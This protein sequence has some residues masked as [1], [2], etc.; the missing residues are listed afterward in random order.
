[1]VVALLPLLVL[2]LAGSFGADLIGADLAPRHDGALAGIWPLAGPVGIVAV[3]LGTAGLAAR[4]LRRPL[5]EASETIEAIMRAELDAAPEAGTERGTEIDRLMG[6]IDRLAEILREQHRRDLVLIEA[7]RKRRSDRRVNLSNMAREIEETTEGGMRVIVEGSCALRE[8]ADD[9]R[10]T[11]ETVQ[12]ASDE[13][14]RAA[15][16][17]R[18][19]NR[20][21]SGLSDRFIAAIGAIAEQAGSGSAASRDAVHRANNARGVISAVAAQTNLL[22]LNATIEAARAGAAGK[23]FAVVASE[24]KSLANETGKST[25][26]IGAKISEIQSRTH[27]VVASLADVT[28]AIGQVS[29]MTDSISTAMQEQRSAMQGFSDNVRQTNAAVSDVAGRMAEIAS[30]VGRSTA[31]ASIV[32]DVAMD[33]ERASQAVRSEIPDI[34]RRALRAD[35]REHPRYDIDARANL[36]AAG[37]SIDIRVLDISESGARI[38]MVEGVELGTALTLTFPGL[39]PVAGRIVRVAEDGFGVGFEPQKLKTEEVR[40]VIAEADGGQPFAQV[41]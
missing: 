1:M 41:G 4:S 7:D 35:L 19:L 36:G 2:F 14:A 3:A 33:M 13:T 21:A 18:M 28:D 20:E 23:G 8:K 40:R 5:A 26:R 15:E 38:A 16:S 27:Q 37:G 6:R 25:E 32:A 11:L 30:M 12:A 29:T 10:T 9:M 17:S 39:H 22:A 31:S 34:V 24:V